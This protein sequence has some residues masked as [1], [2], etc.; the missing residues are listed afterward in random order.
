MKLKALRQKVADLVASA[1]SALDEAEKAETP[2]QKAEFVKKF[3]GIADEI[4]EAK[5]TLAREEK[6]A[7]QERALANFPEDKEDDYKATVTGGELMLAPFENIG[8]MCVAVRTSTLGGG[9]DPRLQM[10]AVVTGAGEGVN[11]DGGFLVQTDIAAGLM[12]RI[13]DVGELRRRVRNIPISSGANGIIIN[14]VDETSRADGSRIGGIRGYWLEEAGATTASRPK[15]RQMEMR[16]RK[17]AALVYA[18]DEL[19]SD[20]S[21]FAS[22]IMEEVPIELAFKVEDAIVNGDGAGKP[23]GFN[24][25]SG[26]SAL[27][28]VAKETGQLA[29]T[30]VVDNIVKMFSRMYS[31]SIRNSV[32]LINQDV[33]PQLF[34]LGVTVG[35]GGVPVYL[36]PGG[37]SGA[38]FA[39]LMGRPVILTEYQSTLGTAGDFMLVDLSQYLTIDKGGVKSDS[40]IH[41]RFLNDESTFRFIYRVDGQPIWNSPLTPF[42]GTNTVS[43]FV[44]LATRA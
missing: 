41:V 2:E 35:T 6:L 11:A 24:V 1:R 10:Q 18:T 28:T 12:K 40:S 38:P 43:P 23:K 33:Q 26:D 42:K 8:E 9:G 21:A 30:I 19:L 13:H 37:I 22:L 27:V 39:S 32:W 25:T 34:T 15:F 7:E 16:L 14:A 29:N 36:P 44:R 20:T 17:I 31:R 5:A 3:D 4:A